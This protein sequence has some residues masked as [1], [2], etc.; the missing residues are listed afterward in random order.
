MVAMTNNLN[1]PAYGVVVVTAGAGEL[2]HHARA[3]RVVGAGTVTI[4]GADGVSCVCTFAAGET[5][6]IRATHI[7]AATA[8]TIEIMY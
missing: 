2:V 3:I 6:N 7:T 8:T 5:R 1:D 4:T